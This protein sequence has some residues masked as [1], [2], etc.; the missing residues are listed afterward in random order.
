[1]AAIAVTEGNEVYV[2]MNGTLIMK[3]YLNNQQSALVFND[4]G[5]PSDGNTSLSYTLNEEGEVVCK[6]K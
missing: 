1:M 6:K 3:K 5:F 2:Y 4:T